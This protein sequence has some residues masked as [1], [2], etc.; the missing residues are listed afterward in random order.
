MRLLC[1]VP[2]FLFLSS[3]SACAEKQEPGPFSVYE[4]QALSFRVYQ[5]RPIYEAGDPNV[6]FFPVLLPGELTFDKAIEG[7]EIPLNTAIVMPSVGEQGL[8][9]IEFMRADLDKDFVQALFYG[10]DARARAHH[11]FAHLGIEAVL[12]DERLILNIH[13]G[14]VLHLRE[15]MDR[16]RSYKTFAN[17]DS[18]GKIT[19]VSGEVYCSVDPDFSK[20]KL[21]AF[22]VSIS[23]GAVGSETP[24]ATVTRKP[25]GSRE[26]SIPGEKL[27]LPKRY[28]QRIVEGP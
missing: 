12:T 27:R 17:P 21:H 8:L 11:P 6:H 19:S 16:S 24:G 13:P 10:G 15:D 28:P 23:A 7:Q 26:I 18:T 3:L 22:Y 4:R 2:T 14:V 9:T 25:D 20:I 1:A 5:G